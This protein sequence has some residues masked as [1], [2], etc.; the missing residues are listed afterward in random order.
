MTWRRSADGWLQAADE[1]R[2]CPECDCLVR[3][4]CEDCQRAR[5]PDCDARWD[6]RDVETAR[7]EAVED[8]QATLAMTDGGE[9]A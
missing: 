4:C 7:S 2:R 9:S 8:G 1:V 6:W 5:C 3:R